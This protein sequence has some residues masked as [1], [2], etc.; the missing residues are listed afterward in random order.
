MQK[1]YDFW[2]AQ[3]ASAKE[4]ARSYWNDADKCAREYCDKS[5]YYNIFYSNVSILDSTLNLANPRP[6]IQRRFLKNIEADKKKS[7][8]YATVAKI[9]NCGVECVSDLSNVNEVMKADV[10]NAN[11]T[12]SGIAWISYEPK[13]YTDEMGVEHIASQDIKCDYL[14]YN[15][16]LRSSAEKQQD[17]WWVAR[18]HL[19]TRGE[20][21]DR[22]GYSADEN[23]LSYKGDET[24][25]TSQKRGEVWEIWDKTDEK[26]IFIMLGHAQKEL[27]EETEDPYSLEC[28]FPCDCLTFVSEENSVVPVAE[29]MLYEK[30][31]DA[32]NKICKKIIDN[33]KSVKYIGVIGS[34]DKS[35][36]QDI[37]RAKDG[38]VLSI[39]VM[40]DVQGNVNNMIGSV[41]VDSV[42]NLLNTLEA[43]KQQTI[44]NIYELT[45]ISDIMRGATDPRETAKAQ[46]IK[47]VFGSLRF[48]DRQ[49]QVQNHR[50]NIYRIIA[51]II[52]EHYDIDTI[53][54]MTGII[55]PHENQKAAIEM[56]VKAL[57]AQGAQIPD[58]LLKQY[59]DIKS[60]PTWEEVLDVLRS[61]KLRN[62]TVEIETTATAFDNKEELTEAINNLTNTYVNMCQIAA[63]LNS[64]ELVKGF[65]PVMKMNIGNCRVSSSVSRQLEEAIE[66][67]YREMDEK[68]KSPAQ[69][70][71]DQIK[72]QT[73]IQ[74]AMK[75]LDVELAKIQGEHQ[76][77]QEEIALR[78]EE[79]AR[80]NRELDAQIFLEQEK[81]NKTGGD[82]NIAGEVRDLI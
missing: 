8:L 15:E 16:F 11:V 20:I 57:Q 67:A 81:L 10:H 24:D 76:Y 29:Y 38:D 58:N 51:E 60:N 27:L 36:A 73:D 48:Q 23:E 13:I 31:A 9:L 55:L 59:E 30:Q 34:Q 40:S 12:G 62:Y 25:E 18:R 69:P 49:K 41:P 54:E 66:G 46:L 47:G 14:K 4:A 17:V 44:Q 7:T 56:Q 75:K 74:I 50:R 2:R 53:Y 32:L 26:R 5:K 3:I 72:A 21:Y 52:A 6:D 19:L 45:G 63:T 35:I 65:I 37:S 61:D 1:D 42:V 82:V 33:Q 71:P 39:P 68:M 78:K 70:T 22:F 80:K 64:P 43:Q 79:E 28:F 77:K